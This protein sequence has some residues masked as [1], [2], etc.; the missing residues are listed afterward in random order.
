MA[1]LLGT[2]YNTSPLEE[3]EIPLGK[4]D[5]LYLDQ[6]RHFFI[7]RNN[8][9]YEYTRDQ[10]T[11]EFKSGSEISFNTFIEA[12]KLIFGFKYNGSSIDFDWIDQF[13]EDGAWKVIADE[14]GNQVSNGLSVSNSASSVGFRVGSATSGVTK[15]VPNNDG[16]FFWYEEGG[17]IGFYKITK[18]GSGARPFIINFYWRALT[19]YYEV[20]IDPGDKGF[21]PIKTI[22]DMR[23]GGKTS[24]SKA[25]Y[26]T[27]K[28]TQPGKPN[29]SKASA[30]GSGFLNAYK[31]QASELAELGKCLWGIPLFTSLSGLFIDPIDSIIS[32]NVFPY[33]PEAGNLE[34]IKILN[35][36]CAPGDL[37]YAALGAPLTS[38]FNIVHFG[39][40]NIYEVFES[41]L[42]YANTNFSLYLPFIGEVSLPINEVMGG[43][44]TVDYTIDF[45][46]GM[47]V[48]NVLCEKNV[49]FSKYDTAE[50]YSQHSYQGNCAIQIPIN[51]KDYGSMIGSLINMCASGL[52]DGIETGSPAAGV[53]SGAL[54]GTADLAAGGFKPSIKTKGALSANA[55][56]CSVYYPYVT[57]ERPIS[58]Q[59]D[60]YQT[61]HGYMSYTNSRL[62]EYE[63]LCVCEDINLSGI[64]NATDSEKERIKT[65]C[66]EGVYV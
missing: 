30:I 55:G 12:L 13:P 33:L 51:S 7:T 52:R 43:R 39:T 18:S 49:D 63:G 66:R 44:I 16:G 37:G 62:S 53:M 8:I 57:I 23:G 58:P 32:L 34:N 42:D 28:L 25:I 40:L 54:H 38:Q 27:D 1:T 46:T 11:I 60:S 36:L 26:T 45:F 3:V 20:D 35:H 59:P 41:F 22:V 5:T 31:V 4:V 24:G 14:Q 19:E 21:V 65:M 9:T 10:Y 64:F 56:F 15:N 29:E 47:C 61:A 6:D 48:A 50:Q 17:L 2:I